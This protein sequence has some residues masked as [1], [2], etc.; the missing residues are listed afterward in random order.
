MEGQIIKRPL[1]SEK[2][3]KG[4]ALNK[5]AFQVNI[6]ANKSQIKR[7]V[8]KVFNVRV[9]KVNTLIQCGKVKKVRQVAGKRPDWKKAIVT[10]V[11]GDKIPFFEGI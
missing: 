4:L 5:Y 2:I 7:A 3:R 8:E 1:L 9:T 11:A 6:K 10:L